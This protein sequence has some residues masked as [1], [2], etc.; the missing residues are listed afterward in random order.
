[1]LL[2]VTEIHGVLLLRSSEVYGCII[3]YLFFLPLRYCGCFRLGYFGE[4]CYE[5]LCTSVPGKMLSFLLGK[6][7]SGGGFLGYMVCK[8]LTFKGS[9]KLVFQTGIPVNVLTNKVSEFHLL[10][11]LTNT[12][13]GQSMLM[14]CYM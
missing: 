7:C 10:Q 5:H 9:T 3:V 1:M 8:C 14:H 11:I 13:R 12:W 2:C 4:N 6:Y